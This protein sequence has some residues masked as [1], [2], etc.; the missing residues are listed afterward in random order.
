MKR[1]LIGYVAIVLVA[2]VSVGLYQQHI[3]HEL[4]V[5]DE[6]SCAQRN[7]LATNQRVV[8]HTLDTLIG[9]HLRELEKPS[10]RDRVVLEE[11][12]QD[13]RARQSKLHIGP[14]NC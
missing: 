13:I 3:N 14:E 5:R 8:L 10:P 1:S 11:V 12:R 7:R 4:K 6:R 2:F 9:L